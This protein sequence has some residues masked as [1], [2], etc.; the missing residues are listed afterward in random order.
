MAETVGTGMSARIKD[1]TPL[2]DLI[3]ELEEPIAWDPLLVSCA[4]AYVAGQI[5]GAVGLPPTDDLRSEIHALF[6]NQARETFERIAGDLAGD[7]PSG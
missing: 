2:L 5:R 7:L 3:K 6:Q 4:K 1:L